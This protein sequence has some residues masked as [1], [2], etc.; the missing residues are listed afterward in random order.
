[1]RIPI[2]EYLMLIAW[3]ASMRSTCPRMKCGA[4]VSYEG[5][6]VSTGYNGA[7]SGMDHCTDVGCQMERVRE[8]DRCV[9]IV[10]A[11]DNA[12]SF[13][14]GRG[15]WLHTTGQPC[16]ECT[17]AIFKYPNIKRVVWWHPYQDSAR[18]DLL[19]NYRG[20]VVFEKLDLPND[21]LQSLEMYYS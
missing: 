12:L 1:M 11:E 9:R 5:R 13:A 17:K 7:P 14:Q 4:L 8:R 19:V 18:D 3:A 15:N 20:P 10:H 21:L 2:D 16:F 6:V